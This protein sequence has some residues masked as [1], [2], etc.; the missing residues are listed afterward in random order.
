MHVK[1]L[2]VNLTFK[3]EEITKL[4]EYL[5]VECFLKY[6]LLRNNKLN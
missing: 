3:E 4:V 5:F 2:S 1:I 6:Q